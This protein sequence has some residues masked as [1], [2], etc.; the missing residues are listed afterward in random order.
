VLAAAVLADRRRRMARALLWTAAAAV[1]LVAAARV[2]P[3]AAGTGPRALDLARAQWPRYHDGGVGFATSR[4][5]KAN[6]GAG[7]VNAGQ[8]LRLQLG[9]DNASAAYTTEVALVTPAEPVF[10]VPD[11]RARALQI[12]TDPM[13]LRLA[14][15]E[16]APTGAY[17]LRVRVLG[18]KDQAV[19]PRSSEGYGLGTLYLG[20]VH[21][22]G[23]G[24]YRT[25]PQHPVSRMGEIVLQAVTAADAGNWLEVTMDWEADRLQVHDY[26]T[27]VRLLDDAGDVLAQDDKMPVYGYLP[28]T[29]WPAGQMVRD[30]R[31]IP[32]AD[33]TPSGST[34]RVEVVLYDE[35]SGERIGQAQ[36][37]GITVRQGG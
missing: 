24:D 1:V 20:P 33:D 26:K 35:R 32:L 2:M 29:S 15:P 17:F 28:T 7:T 19:P 23:H 14:V 36:V 12:Q 37:G 21:V 13:A 5:V 8:D 11:V 10:G 18:A 4:L 3:R 16:D 27:S 30:R 22:E 25:R 31:W 9:W 34:Y 6:Y